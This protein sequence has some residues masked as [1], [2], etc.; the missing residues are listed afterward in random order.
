MSA[1][2]GLT[3]DRPDCTEAI[4]DVHTLSR[5]LQSTAGQTIGS[6]AYFHLDGLTYSPAGRHVHF[7]ST[8]SDPL[9][10]NFIS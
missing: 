5:S 4:D 10:Y 6:N 2:P 3:G 7:I 9:K 8:P 1:T